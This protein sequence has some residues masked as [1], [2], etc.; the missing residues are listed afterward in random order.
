MTPTTPSGVATRSMT[1]PF[2]R[3]NRA[4]T[5]P[6]GSGK[7][8]ISSSPRAIASMRFSSS[9]SRSRKA[10]AT[11][12]ALAAATSRALAARM[13]AALPRSDPAA[14]TRARSFCARGALARTRAARRASAPI[15]RIAA[16]TSSDACATGRREVI[17]VSLTSLTI[18]APFSTSARA[19]PNQRRAHKRGRQ[20]PESIAVGRL[21]IP[22]R[23]RLETIF[24]GA[25]QVQFVRRVLA[26]PA[27]DAHR[28]A[29]DVAVNMDRRAFGPN[30]IVQDS[31]VSRRQA[32]AAM[33]RRLSQRADG[34][35]AMDRI[36]RQKEDRM[37]HRRIVVFERMDHWIERDRPEIAVRR[38]M[39][40][41][42]G[43]D[44]P[45]VLFARI[46]G[47]VHALRRK[48]DIDADHGP[49]PRRRKKSRASER[50]ER[51]DTTH[52]TLLTSP[53]TPP[54]KLAGPR[55]KI[56]QDG[57]KLRGNANCWA[58]ARADRHALAWRS[59][60]VI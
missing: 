16:P 33:R 55:D 44:G 51:Q 30:H 58:A 56:K 59:A 8:A 25:V 2:G 5:Q 35:G 32:H 15:A 42:A 4:R 38:H 41:A 52:E 47:D 48:I 1:R 36:V 49:R 19:D 9:I 31:S 10:E 28:G 7:A 40:L 45:I 46:R 13:S 37:R 18:G 21:E 20:K 11:P 14:A 29:A 34:V 12:R 53:P 17:F 57:R 39:T 27:H 54:L 50:E 23:K 3:S 6:T 60:S 43:R 22:S 24:R 26:M